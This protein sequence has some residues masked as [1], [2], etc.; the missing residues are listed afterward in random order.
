MGKL[1]KAVISLDDITEACESGDYIGF[2]LECGDEASG[3]E[4]DARNYNCESCGA[5]E[6]YGAQELLI[7]GVGV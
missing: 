5:K 3:V 6:V 1:C 2:C 4:P 7:M